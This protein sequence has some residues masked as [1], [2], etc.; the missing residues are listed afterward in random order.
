MNYKSSLREQKIFYDKLYP[1]TFGSGIFLSL[2]ELGIVDRVGYFRYVLYAEIHHYA[3]DP[4]G[5]VDGNVLPG[6]V[7]LKEQVQESSIDERSHRNDVFFLGGDGEIPEDLVGGSLQHRLHSGYE[8]TAEI[9]L[10]QVEVE[11]VLLGDELAQLKEYRVCT[12]H[13]AGAVK[14]R[15]YGSE[16]VHDLGFRFVKDIRDVAVV[17]VESPAVD[18]G[19][20]REFAYRDGGDVLA[21][22]DLEQG[23]ADCFLGADNSLI[24][25][26][27]CCYCHNRLP[28]FTDCAFIHICIL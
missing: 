26:V 20:S 21:F 28:F 1:G 13:Q 3:C 6:F 11:S 10:H 27:A 17:G 18:I 4:G 9:A 19:K 8:H 23:G 14:A 16:G 2:C 7:P 24:A 22:H 15:D 5:C 25:V 12:V